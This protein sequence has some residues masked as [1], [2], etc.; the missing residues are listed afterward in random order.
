MEYMTTH[1]IV[2]VNTTVTGSTNRFDYVALEAAMAAQ[3]QYGESRDVQAQSANL[4]DR[5][6]F[7]PPFAVGIKRTALISVLTFLNGN[8]YATKA[9]DSEAARILLAVLARTRTA[10]E[11]IAELAAPAETPLPGGSTLRKLIAHECNAHI[12]ALTALTENDG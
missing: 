11:A 12:E 1:D 4:L 6:L 8:G 9:A 7:H 10:A 3:Y 5:L 2:W